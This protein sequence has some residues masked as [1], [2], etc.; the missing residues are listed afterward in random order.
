MIS[1]MHCVDLIARA[2]FELSNVT[3]KGG[4]FNTDPVG[5][6]SEEDCRLACNA[7]EKCNFFFWRIDNHCSMHEVCGELGISQKPG[8]IYAKNGECQ[9]IILISLM[10][11]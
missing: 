9:G 11:T 6:M 10:R 8:I 1:I 5:T 2:C 3:C 4:R 7:E